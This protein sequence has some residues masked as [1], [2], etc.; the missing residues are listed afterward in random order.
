MAFFKADADGRC[1]KN[2]KADAD[3]DGRCLVVIFDVTYLIKGNSKMKHPNERNNE[4]NEADVHV[5]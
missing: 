1:S 5:L 2:N 4:L 3:A